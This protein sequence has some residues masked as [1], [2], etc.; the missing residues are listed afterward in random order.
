MWTTSKFELTWAKLGFISVFLGD[1]FLDT[2]FSLFDSS[3]HS[4]LSL[5]QFSRFLLVEGLSICSDWNSDL[6]I[7][8]VWFI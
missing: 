5:S 7:R 2:P 4:S 1:H 6:F 8:I 3:S